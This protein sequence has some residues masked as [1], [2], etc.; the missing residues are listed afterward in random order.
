MDSFVTEENGPD[1]PRDISLES[2]RTIEEHVLGPAR[3]EIRPMIREEVDMMN[4]LTTMDV[5]SMNVIDIAEFRVCHLF[6]D[7][8]G[9]LTKL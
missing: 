2:E 9:R 7:F 4:I 8:A 6:H 3:S 1:P 5:Q